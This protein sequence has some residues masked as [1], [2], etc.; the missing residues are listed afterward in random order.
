MISVR[1]NHLSLKYQRFTPSGYKD[2][3]IRK[4]KFAAKTQFLCKSIYIYLYIVIRHGL[5]KFMHIELHTLFPFRYKDYS[6]VTFIHSG[7]KN[8]RTTTFIH[9]KSLILYILIISYK[10]LRFPG[11]VWIKQWWIWKCLN[12]QKVE[13]SFTVVICI[14]M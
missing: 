9:T 3:G 6:N 7:N 4:F 10:I 14:Q 8:N 1:S 5:F 13:S 2:I 11:L 12:V